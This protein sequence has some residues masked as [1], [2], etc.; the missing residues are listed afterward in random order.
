MYLVCTRMPDGVTVGE[1]CLC[2]CVLQAVLFPSTDYH[3]TLTSLFT[4]CSEVAEI[5]VPSAENQELSNVFTSKPGVGQNIA[6]HV[7]PT[8]CRNSSHLIYAST[9]QT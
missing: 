7:P 5:K 6:L 3:C 8:A 9:L 1:S 4:P 2:C